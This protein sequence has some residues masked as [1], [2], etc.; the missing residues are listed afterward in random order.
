MRSVLRTLLVAILGAALLAACAGNPGK[1]PPAKILYGRAQSSLSLHNWKQ[2]AT[3]FRN[4]IST[5]PFGKYATSARLRLIYAYYRAGSTDRAARQASH[6]LKENPASRYADYALFMKG[7]AYAS[8][9]QPGFL[10]S[11]F[12]VDMAERA[13]IDQRKA[14]TAFQQ[15][16]KRYPHTPYAHKAR[17]WMVFV[18][19]RLARHNLGIAQFY[20]ARE[21]WVAAINRANIVVTRFPHTPSA[22]RAF[23]IL[24]Q[25]YRALGEDKLASAAQAWLEY[26]YRQK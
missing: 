18:R 22:K 3:R 14:Y 6:F 7:I 19:N 26:N 15:L 16:M 20:A 1:V 5:Y 25:A 12:N 4:F 24:A 21:Q 9:M 13:P 2:A 8:T 17:Q 10:D 23:A 11:L